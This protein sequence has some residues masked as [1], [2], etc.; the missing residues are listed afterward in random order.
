MPCLSVGLGR[1]SKKNQQ[2]RRKVVQVLDESGDVERL[3]AGE[4]IDVF[5]A[6]PSGEAP[7]HVMNQVQGAQF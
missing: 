1:V 4:L 5:T 6:A 3:D 2:R 7:C